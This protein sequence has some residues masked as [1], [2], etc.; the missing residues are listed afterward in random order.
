MTLVLRPARR[1]TRALAK[2]FFRR[3]GLFPKAR[4]ATTSNRSRARRKQFRQATTATI[5][6]P[7]RSNLRV[8]RFHLRGVALPLPQALALALTPA[9]KITAVISG[10]SGSWGFSCRE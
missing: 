6:A 7:F 8:D 4:F 1:L 5:P 3:H 2:C 9:H 10:R